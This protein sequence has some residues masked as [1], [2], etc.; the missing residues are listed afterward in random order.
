MTE[1]NTTL[2][3]NMMAAF[4]AEAADGAVS[5]RLRGDFYGH[6]DNVQAHRVCV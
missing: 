5:D 2:R 4:N 1:L 3:Q 6:G